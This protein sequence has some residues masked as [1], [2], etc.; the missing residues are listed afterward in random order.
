MG[1]HNIYVTEVARIVQGTVHRHYKFEAD[2]P[3]EAEKLYKKY[4]EE[5]TLHNYLEESDEYIKE[6][7]YLEHEVQ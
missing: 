7:E 6:T 4:S 1:K 2:T 5:G 3:E